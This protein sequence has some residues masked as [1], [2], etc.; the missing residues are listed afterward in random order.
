[1]ETRTFED[2]RDEVMVLYGEQKFGEVYDRLTAEAGHFP[3]NAYDVLYL[4]SCMAVRTGRPELALQLIRESLDRG[5][6]FGEEVLRSSPSWAPL[7][8]VPEFEE[9]ATVS[10]ER[11][12]DAYIGPLMQVVEPVGGCT[13]DAPCPTVIALHGNGS[14]LPQSLRGWR[15]LPEEGWLLAGV[16]SSQIAGY[17]SFIWDNQDVALS[18]VAE[19]YASLVE[20]YNVDAGRVVLAGFSMGGA[21]TLHAVLKNTIPVEGFILLGPGGGYIDTP[22]EIIP[23]LESAKGRNLRGYVFLGEQDETIPQD[24]VRRIVDLLNEQG[25]STR[26]EVIP[27]VRHDYPP[28]FADHI[29]RALS[30]IEGGD[31]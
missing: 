20:R 8:G 1:L 12:K 17:N 23:L 30:F 6:W 13:A 31:D 22:D 14:N 16:Q 11:A 26:L 10:M 27:G 18:E 7:Q 25:I 2:F 15:S 19:H 21:T 29:K 4:R 24:N 9:L 3:D 28:T 5:F